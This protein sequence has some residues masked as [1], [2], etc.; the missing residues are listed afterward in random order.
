MLTL[1][2]PFS[3]IVFFAVL[4]GISRYH[5]VSLNMINVVLCLQAMRTILLMQMG[6][7]MDQFLFIVVS[8]LLYNE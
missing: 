8:G 4:P 5:K 1:C 7:S 2:V 3:T 6:Q